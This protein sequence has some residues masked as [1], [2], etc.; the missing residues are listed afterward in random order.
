MIGVFSCSHS[1][2][3]LRAVLLLQDS[4]LTSHLVAGSFSPAESRTFAS[5]KISPNFARRFCR[6]CRYSPTASKS[7]VSKTP[8]SPKNRPSRW[9]TAGTASTQSVRKIPECSVRPALCVVALVIGRTPDSAMLPLQ[10]TPQKIRTPVLPK[11][12]KFTNSFQINH[13]QSINFPEKPPCRWQSA[14][15][16][17]IHFIRKIIS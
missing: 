3:N 12:P 5:P 15:T 10:K 11:L 9:Q 17:S 2:G 13:F 14:S 1:T 16:A 7:A 4:R 6:N 8:V